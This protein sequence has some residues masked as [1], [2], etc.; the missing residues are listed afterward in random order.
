MVVVVT[1]DHATHGGISH[2]RLRHAQQ[3]ES[4]PN[5]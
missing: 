2:V 1:T 3:M 5:M 4:T